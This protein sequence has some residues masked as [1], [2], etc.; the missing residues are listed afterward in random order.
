MDAS[1]ELE[2]F[3]QI[4]RRTVR[5]AQVEVSE[6]VGTEAADIVRRKTQ[7]KCRNRIF[8]PVTGD[9]NNLLE[10]ESAHLIAHAA[11]GSA[12]KG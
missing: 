4:Q 3:P 12:F 6:E 7:C 1:Y 2:V 5:Q 10:V 8:D 11:D 9:K